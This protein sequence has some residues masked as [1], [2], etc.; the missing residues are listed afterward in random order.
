[1]PQRAAWQDQREFEQQHRQAAKITQQRAVLFTHDQSAATPG[2]EIEERGN[3]GERER[4]NNAGEETVRA[5]ATSRGRP[6]EL[7]TSRGALAF[8][9]PFVFLHL[10]QTSQPSGGEREQISEAL[11]WVRD[12]PA[13]FAQYN[14]VMTARVRLLFFWIGKDDVG[15][16]YIRHG[17]SAQDPRKEMIQVLFGSDPA[18]APRAINRWGSG[19]EMQWHKDPVNPASAARSNGV[20]HSA[21]FGFMKS[22]KGKSV[23]EMQEELKKEGEHGEHLFTGILSRAEPGQALSTVVPLASD[24]DYNLHQYDSAEPIMIE[25]LA[26][27]DRPI[28]SLNDAAG[29]GRAEEF[30]GTMSELID[31]ALRGE[32][33]K[34][35]L[36]YVYDAQVHTL[37]LEH[38]EPVKSVSIKVQAAKSGTLIEKT[39][40]DLI[41]ADFMSSQASTGKKTYFTILIGTKGELR[42][43]PVQIRYQPN[44][45]FQ[46]VL[47]LL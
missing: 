42:G 41:E 44:W 43:V 35:S 45:W 6:S 39:Y 12:T 46:V 19:V 4:R 16:G 22:S 8:L 3:H 24:T 36:C 20:V 17:I 27:S 10:L 28:R 18:K 13:N 32:K 2:K 5:Q 38:T 47:N 23:G 31:K 14:Y 1:M 25:R 29:C 15:G 9:L 37:T 26:S 40:E 11:G 30:L 33:R 21:F 7:L 34:V